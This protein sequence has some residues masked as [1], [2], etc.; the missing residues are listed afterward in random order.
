MKTGNVIRVQ[1]HRK[2]A[3][4]SQ[5]MLRD[6]RLSFAARG[7]LSYLLSKPDDWEM[8]TDDLINQ[9]PAGRDAVYAMLKELEKCGYLVRRRVHVEKGRVTWQTTVFET[10]ELATALSDPYREKPETV[11]PITAFPDTVSPNTE[12]ADTGSPYTEKPHS[13]EV[14]TDKEVLSEELP[15][16]EKLNNEK[17]KRPLDSPAAAA[18]PVHSVFEY[19]RTKTGHTQAKLTPERDRIIRLRLKDYTADELM[20][21]IDGCLV[22]PFHMGQNDRHT[23]YD[24]LKTIFRDGEQVEKFIAMSEANGNGKSQSLA[25]PSR[26][27]LTADEIDELARTVKQMLAE[28]RKFNEVEAQLSPSVRPYDWRKVRSIVGVPNEPVP[29]P[30]TATIA[31]NI[32]AGMQMPS[33]PG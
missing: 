11:S 25:A 32:A 1:R 10:P 9:S 23:V 30:A 16:K 33:K 7:L 22:S 28:G 31:Q 15:S 24:G 26:P 5:D 20:R 27:A 4:I 29:V 13:K 18:S 21:A 17:N 6:S 19:W 2:Y 8:R 3:V 12:K 14:P